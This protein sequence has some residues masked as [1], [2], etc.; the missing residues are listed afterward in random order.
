VRFYVATIKSEGIVMPAE[1]ELLSVEVR[2]Q[3]DRIPEAKLV[4][5][6]GS[7]AAGK[8]SLSNTDFFAPGKTVQILL[9]YGDGKD[10]QVFAGL[11]VRHSVEARDDA[12]ELRVE[13]KDA[14][15]AMTRARR[16]AVYR[17]QRDDEVLGALIAR[18]G[19]RRGVIDRSAVTHGQLVQHNASDWDFLLSRADVNGQVVIVDDGT[20]SVRAMGAAGKLKA[21]FTYGLSEIADLSLELDGSSQWG[22]V[23]STAWD[24]TNVAQ[25][26]P[27]AALRSASPPATSRSTPSLPSSAATATRC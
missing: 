12:S 6:D 10:Q 13:L 16:S 26:R 1:V 22:A 14:A 20:L 7:V 3:L 19:L 4:L 15:H 11:V 9:R 8:F 21:S 17:D 5:V 25:A 23:T 18:A 24:P 27:R 2:K